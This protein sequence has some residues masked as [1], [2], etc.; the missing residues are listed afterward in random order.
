[1]KKYWLLVIF[2]GILVSTGIFWYAC[3]FHVRRTSGPLSQD[4]YIWQRNWNEPVRRA[5]TKAGRSFDVLV[6]LVAEVSWETGR[7]RIVRIDPDYAPLLAAGGHVGLALRIGAYSGP[8]A[9]TGE[10]A[11]TIAA[12]AAEQLARANAAELI[13]VELQLDFDCAEAKLDGYRE[14]A[15]AIR[16]RI[17]PTPLVI[18]ALPSWLDRREFRRLAAATDG[19]VLQVHSLERPN[20]P[21][22]PMTL[23]DPAAARRA[24]EAAGRVGAPFRVALGTYGYVVGFDR[25]GKLLGLQAE[26]P[27]LSWPADAELRVLRSD[28]EAAAA[29]VRDWHADRPATMRGLI[30]YRLPTDA[31]ALNWR[32]P[33]L[34]AVMAGRT[35]R[36]KLHVETVRPEPGLIELFLVNAGDADAA[37]PAAV[38]ASWPDAQLLAGDALTG[39]QLERGGPCEICFRRRSDAELQW[40]PPAERRMLGWLRL[41]VDTEVE[42][43]VT[44]GKR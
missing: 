28:P 3:F 38:E 9:A 10:P 1:M 13:P 14:W 36:G 42:A 22:Q 12:L 18:T 7:P 23:C 39:F 35:P 29:M 8:F 40:L 33:T 15:T 34:A 31:D 11:E 25:D 41:A 43:H 21:D 19:F 32:W 37:L 26:G 17:S 27:A 5:V 6:A 2:P 24:V 30:W 20:R 4:A 16:A 44:A